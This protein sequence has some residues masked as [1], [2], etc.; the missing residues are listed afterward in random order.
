M[1]ILKHLCTTL[2]TAASFASFAQLSG[3]YTINPVGGN[4]TTIGAAVAALSSSGVNGPVTFSIAPGIY[5]EKLVFGTIAGVSA[6]NTVLFIASTN[7]AS[8]VNI[9]PAPDGT[10]TIDLGTTRR[11][12]FQYLTI[13]SAGKGVVGSYP[14]NCDFLDCAI[15]GRANGTTSHGFDI[16]RTE[17]MKVHRCVVTNVDHAI[18][19]GDI[20]GALASLNV[21]VMSC[22]VGAACDGIR[23]TAVQDLW[24]QHNTVAVDGSCSTYGSGIELSGNTGVV[25][26]TGNTVTADANATCLY[27]QNQAGTANQRARVVNNMLICTADGLL[28]IAFS[29]TN[30]AYI[31]VYHNSVLVTNGFANAVASYNSGNLRFRGNIVKMN[32]DGLYYYMETPTGP[33]TFNHNMYHAAN[34]GQFVVGSNFYGFTAWQTAGYDASGLEQDPLFTSN[35]DLH[36][37]NASPAQNKV[38]TNLGVNE[39]I[40]QHGRPSPVFTIADMGCDERTQFWQQPLAPQQHADA[41]ATPEQFYPN[42]VSDML[43]ANGL[44]GDA[45]P[46]TLYNADGRVALSGT[47]A[48]RSPIHLGGLG[49][50]T[51]LLVLADRAAPWRI[52]VQH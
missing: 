14:R 38:P 8:D 27:V 13:R 11:V 40:D 15:T 2:L 6:T 49:N 51:Y 17:R 46:F 31:D 42:P 16:S 5:A 41:G 50:G 4:Y 32:D 36:L 9:G 30:V 33:F 25:R 10:H 3:N 28:P 20:G 44:G 1:R 19:L 24:I 35:T 47:V 22:T 48:E 52:V 18:I 23:T 21:E 43:Y 12:N 39:D 26:V 29:M 7:V 34:G 37:T 45:V